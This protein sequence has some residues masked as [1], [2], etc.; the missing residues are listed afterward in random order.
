MERQRSKGSTG[1]AIR[2]NCIEGE[3]QPPPVLL[4]VSGTT[5]DRSDCVSSMT[6]PFALLAQLVEQDPFKV[7]VVES[8][9]TAPTTVYGEPVEVWH[10]DSELMPQTKD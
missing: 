1:M 9:S 4:I 6:K 7:E 10:K 2:G 3:H 8:Y 5:R